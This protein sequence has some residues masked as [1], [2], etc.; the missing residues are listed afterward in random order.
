MGVNNIREYLCPFHAHSYLPVLQ[1]CFTYQ[2][3]RSES[4]VR[5]FPVFFSANSRRVH[6]AVLAFVWVTGLICGAVTAGSAGSSF[7]SLMRFAPS[8]QMS[9][10]SL[11]ISVLLPLLVSAIASNCF[12]YWLLCLFAF[13]RAFLLSCILFGVAIAYGSAGW[14]IG[15]L[16]LFS[17]ILSAPVL[18]WYWFRSIA[19]SKSTF[20]CG[21]VVLL[22]LILIG[23]FDGRFVAPFLANLLTL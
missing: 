20:R 12:R 5:F 22:L 10:V 8:G 9:I 1:M 2:S 11:L 6:V 7:H 14:L 23:L 16:F 19:G 15:F 17:D 3:R 4:M 18:V 21:T 13:V